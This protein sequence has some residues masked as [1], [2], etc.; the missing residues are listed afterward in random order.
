VLAFSFSR[1]YE[2]DDNNEPT[3]NILKIMVVVDDRTQE[4]ELA[5]ELERQSQEHVARIEKLY[6][7]LRLDPAVFNNF[8][9]DTADAL[10]GVKTKINEL[11]GDPARNKDIIEECF[12]VVHSLKGEARSLNLES[13]SK[14][15]HSVEEEIS[16]LREAAAG[17][18]DQGLKDRI[19]KQIAQ[20]SE[21]IRDGS[22][23]FEK[24]MNM[25]EAFQIKEE[26]PIRD[27][28]N[29]MRGIIKKETEAAGKPIDFVFR[30]NAGA[31]IPE[32]ILKNLKSPVMQIMRNAVDHGIESGEE[33]ARRGKPQTGQIR[34]TL[35]MEES[36]LIVACE[37]DGQ[38]LDAERIKEKALEGR[39]IT[40]DEAGQMSLGDV[41]RLIF[42]SGLSTASRVTETSGRGVGMDIVRA[43]L[44]EMNAIIS[45][46]TEYTIHTKFFIYIPTE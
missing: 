27:F 10:D 29:A 20:L 19:L 13:V 3:E 4:Y 44:K 36:S 15:A 33:R 7:V 14:T 25:R 1:I 18:V 34:L 24:V 45:I 40:A 6:Q 16:A 46:K 22:A 2:I 5:K 28:E 21:E 31:A 38:G 8:V 11:N 41:H 39:F 26:D 35:S 43:A 32:D 37:D 17:S 30:N 42:L 12:R 9:R 23:L